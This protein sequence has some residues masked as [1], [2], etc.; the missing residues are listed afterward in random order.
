M[1]LKL[2][3]GALP[4]G[5]RFDH[6]ASLVATF[7]GVGF[8]P[9]AAGTWGSLAA[10]PCAWLIHYWFG[11]SGMAIAAM[12]LA[13][14]GVWAAEEIVRRGNVRDPGFIV[15]DEVAGQFLALLFA[16][17]GL[18]S[19]LAAFLLFRAADIVKPF[20]ANWCDRN[21]HGGFGVML[22]DIVAG[23]YA[24]VAVWFFAKLGVFA[25]VERLLG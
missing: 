13:L 8:A 17:V 24:G 12:A 4:E 19:W 23:V 7:G 6:P 20:P 3:P 18:A 22:D 21:L 10:L 1:R 16:P 5:M 15:I 9:L 2:R 11:W 25:H 14:L